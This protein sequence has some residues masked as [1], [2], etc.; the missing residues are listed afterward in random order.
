MAAVSARRLPIRAKDLRLRCGKGQHLEPKL[1]DESFGPQPSDCRHGARS[2][3]RFPRSPG[4]PIRFGVTT[5]HTPPAEAR[6]AVSATSG[7][8]VFARAESLLELS[9]LTVPPGNHRE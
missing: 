4:F 7:A 1:A 2:G 5:F 3:L 6:S 8:Q 9:D